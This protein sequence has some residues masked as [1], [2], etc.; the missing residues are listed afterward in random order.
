ML[1][2][3]LNSELKFMLNFDSQREAHNRGSMDY[4]DM[5]FAEPMLVILIRAF[6]LLIK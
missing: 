1:Y 6:H 2:E 3:E 5:Q 4:D